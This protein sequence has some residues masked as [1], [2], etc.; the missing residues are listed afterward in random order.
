MNNLKNFLLALSL[1]FTTQSF[2]SFMS[3]DVCSDAFEVYCGTVLISDWSDATNIDDPEYS[4]CFYPNSREGVWYKII[5]NG[6]I[7]KASLCNYTTEIHVFDGTCDNLTCTESVTEHYYY[8]CEGSSSEVSFLSELGKVYYLYCK[9]LNPHL[10]SRLTLTCMTPVANN[11]CNDSQNILIDETYALDHLAASLSADGGCPNPQT[12]Y[13]DSWYSFLGNDSFGLFTEDCNYCS[14]QFTMYKGSDCAAMECLD[15]IDF[16]SG[17][18]Y[19]FDQGENYYLQVMT[20]SVNDYAFSI[21]SFE[22]I[23]NDSCLYAEQ[24]LVGSDIPFELDYATPDESNCTYSYRRGIWYEFEG[25]G[26]I[27]SFMTDGYN[28]SIDIFGGTCDDLVCIENTSTSAMVSILSENNTV[29]YANVYGSANGVDTLRS[30]IIV[31]VS[32]NNPDGAEMLTCGQQITGTLMAATSNS[33]I[34]NSENPGVWYSVEGTNEFYSVTAQ[35]LTA[36]FYY[37]SITIYD[38]SFSSIYYYNDPIFL[39]SGRTYFIHTSDQTFTDSFN[40]ELQCFPLAINDICSSAI[41]IDFLDTITGSTLFSNINTNEDCGYYDTNRSDIWYYF[42]G[43]GQLR[44]LFFS[45]GRHSMAIFSGTCSALLCAETGLNRPYWV[46]AD[47]IRFFFELNNDYYFKLFNSNS[48]SVSNEF[49]FWTDEL[50]VAEN[51]LCQQA[52][53]LSCGDIVIDSTDFALPDYS[54]C[55]MTDPYHGVIWYSFEG[56]GEYVKITDTNSD[57]WNGYDLQLYSGLCSD[58]VCLNNELIEDGWSQI[59]YAEA[60]LNYYFSVGHYSGPFQFKISCSEP[61][62]NSNFQNATEIVCGENYSG[63]EFFG[64]VQEVYSCP[65]SSVPDGNIWFTISGNDE[66]VYVNDDASAFRSCSIFTLLNNEPTC[67]D[68]LSEN[69]IY[70]PAGQDYYFRF[71]TYDYNANSYH[72]NISFTCHSKVEND[73]CVTALLMTCGE[74]VLID[75]THATDDDNDQSCGGSPEDRAIWFTVEGD[76]SWKHFEFKDS[77]GM[78]VNFQDWSYEGSCNNLECLDFDNVF[79]AESGKNYYIS[80]SRGYYLGLTEISLGC[81]ETVEND[82]CSDA[83]QLMCGDTINSTFDYAMLCDDEDPCTYGNNI[84]K[85]V[86]FSVVGTSDFINIQFIGEAYN[87]HTIELEIYENGCCHLSQ[88]MNQYG[89]DQNNI[90][91][92]SDQG[93]EYLIS[94]RLGAVSDNGDYQ[95]IIKCFDQN[96]FNLCEN[97]QTVVDQQTVLLNPKMGL[98]YLPN[99]DFHYDDPLSWVRFEGSGFVDTIVIVSDNASSLSTRFYV[100]ADQNCSLLG[101]LELSSK[102]IYYQ[103]DSVVYVL[104]TQANHSYVVGINESSYYNVENE[105]VSVTKYNGNSVS[106][107]C[108]IEIDQIVYSNDNLEGTIFIDIDESFGPYTI[109]IPDDN[110]GNWFTIEEDQWI[111]IRTSNLGYKVLDYRSDTYNDNSSNLVCAG[112]TVFEFV[113]ESCFEFDASLCNDVEFQLDE[114]GSISVNP[115][116]IY[117]NTGLNCNDISFYLSKTNFDCND[118]GSNQVTLTI[119]E[120][121]SVYECTA[122]VVIVDLFNAQDFCHDIELS[123]DHNGVATLNF[124]ELNSIACGLESFDLSQ[125][126]FSCIDL[127]ANDISVSFE[128]RAGNVYDCQFIVTVLET[129]YQDDNAKIIGPTNLCFNMSEISFYIEENENIEEYQWSYSNSGAHI[130]SNENNVVVSPAI[131]SRLIDGIL[132]VDL[133]SVCGTLLDSYSHQLHFYNEEFCNLSSCETEYLRVYNKN[134]HLFGPIDVFRANRV[135]ESDVTFDDDDVKF[136]QAGE[137]IN[138]ISDF[139]IKLGAEFTAEIIPCEN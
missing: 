9:T 51:D 103:S 23:P 10:G 49:Q 121:C 8:L 56:T 126:E 91:F 135:I 101:H 138:L 11:F 58:L 74:T 32:N 39:E 100:D 108:L 70:L 86:W 78:E 40:L 139:E 125:S 105:E 4:D 104:S 133:Y 15:P 24:Y 21:Q 44:D 37:P 93:T 131:A 46:D 123:L 42:K 112:N 14:L 81:H 68:D 66:F 118:I 82:I 87:D 45:E 97:A 55:D 83:L 59:F 129:P 30:E 20:N 47:S 25:N 132:T 79:Y 116:D 115:S 99:D 98:N 113:K 136:Y 57:Y 107:Q 17:Q 75:R 90:Y 53:L 2:A 19:Y 85:K 65:Y 111:T 3:N 41:E 63:Y 94:A 89:N 33:E 128:D 73:D 134:I 120:S 38:D 61:L 18:G 7:I 106:N 28:T 34:T 84:E 130:S 72:Y 102:I 71:C 5:G 137:Q 69:R 31:P 1:F 95:M 77:L 52:K 6:E 36:P 35:F 60:G 50:L 27:I 117:S 119:E 62:G 22:E 54:L 26:N 114:N 16:N 64:N 29:Y 12:Y 109:L 96:D 122:D 110:Y 124:L 92:Q 88:L 67:F 80:I 43:D 76:N 13:A 127:G 48:S